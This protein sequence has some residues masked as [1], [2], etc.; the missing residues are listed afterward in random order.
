M[1][2]SVTT[3]ALTSALTG[4]SQRQRAIADNIANVNTSGYRAQVVSFE[5]EL[6]RS[7]ER[8][9]GAV[10]PTVRASTAPTRLNGNNVNLDTE[11]LANIETVLRYQ[12]AAQA[13]GGTFSSLQTA[14]R[15]S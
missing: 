10:S 8:G 3:T 1:L 2:E 4:L 7:V 15:T 6:A 14:M 9:D 13:V 12:F 5:A 11:T